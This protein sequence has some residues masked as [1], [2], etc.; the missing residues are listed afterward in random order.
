MW[1]YHT[2]SRIQ[3]PQGILGS[4]SFMDNIKKNSIR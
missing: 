2:A 3:L 1:Q 4:L